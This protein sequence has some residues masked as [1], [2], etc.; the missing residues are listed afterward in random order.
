M[1]EPASLNGDVARG[2]DA[3]GV[4]RKHRSTGCLGLKPARSTGNSN[5]RSFDRRCQ[6]PRCPQ[7]YARAG[8]QLRWAN[9]MILPWFFSRPTPGIAIALIVHT[10]CQAGTP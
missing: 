6:D 3:V 4:L 9:A 7:G 1:P 8:D 5:C 10:V 2:R